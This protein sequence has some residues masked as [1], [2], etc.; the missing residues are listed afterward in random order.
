MHMQYKV[1][2]MILGIGKKSHNF[3]LTKNKQLGQVRSTDVRAQS[4][5]I[6][7]NPW[8]SSKIMDFPDLRVLRFHSQLFQK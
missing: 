8:K 1:T 4:M 6:Y 3:F 7:G 5:K 2:E